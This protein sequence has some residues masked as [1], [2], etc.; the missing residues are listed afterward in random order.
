[1]KADQEFWRRVESEVQKTGKLPP[2]FRHVC[3]TAHHCGLLVAGL[4]DGV[5]GPRTQRLL[6]E[7]KVVRMDEYEEDQY[8]RRLGRSKL[9]PRKSKSSRKKKKG[10][11]PVPSKK[12]KRKRLS[13]SGRSS[14]AAEITKD[15][16]DM[17]EEEDEDLDPAEDEKQDSEEGEGHGSVQS[18]GDSGPRDPRTPSSR[19]SRRRH[20]FVESLEPPRKKH[21]AEA[22]AGPE[23]R[24]KV[25]Q[26]GDSGLGGF[27][28]TI[29]ADASAAA[30][31]DGSGSHRFSGS[32]I[33]TV[34][35][36]LAAVVGKKPDSNWSHRPSVP[37]PQ[38]GEELEFSTPLRVSSA[39]VRDWE[40]SRYNPRYLIPTLSPFASGRCTPNLPE[41]G[42][43][44]HEEEEEELMEQGKE[45]SLVQDDTKWL[46]GGGLPPV[47]CEPVDADCSAPPPH[48]APPR[49]HGE[50][51]STDVWEPH[52]HE[53][54]LARS[55]S[56]TLGTVTW[57][58]RSFCWV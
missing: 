20:D 4:L 5:P 7:L 11:E 38:L 56:G 46:L 36:V 22:G 15:D 29:P 17:E 23:E 51:N 34:A 47:S 40:Q 28:S 32:S 10:M 27:P 48:Y 19:S 45:E 58:Q 43:S 41:F 13:S 44:E 1:M 33:A 42:D 53:D 6:M 12:L 50:S 3:Q 21:K 18:P 24:K 52:F 2:A 30:P 49:D 57:R 8:Q 39:D 14:A 16:S 9:G 25:A 26:E 54:L 31:H 35:S 55:S 37:Q